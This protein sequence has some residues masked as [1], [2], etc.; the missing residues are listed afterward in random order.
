MQVS[1][2]AKA[3][4]I[5]K[6]AKMIVTI[7]IIC[8]LLAVLY[9]YLRWPYDYWTKRGVPGPSP[10]IVVGNFKS[11]LTQK[12]ALAVEMDDIYRYEDCGKRI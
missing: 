1:L 5:S 4:N 9:C 11:T 12:N 3:V 2:V 8:V 7:S 10:T 6:C